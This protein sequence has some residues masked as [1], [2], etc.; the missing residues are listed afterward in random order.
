MSPLITFVDKNNRQII[1]W[2]AK[3]HNFIGH[4]KEWD[5]RSIG[6]LLPSNVIANIKATPIPFSP[7]EDRCF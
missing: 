6:M 3:V 5:I 1:N 2:Y 7:M 4:D